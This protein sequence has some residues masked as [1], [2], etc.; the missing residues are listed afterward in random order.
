METFFTL[1][2]PVKLSLTSSEH[3]R[4]GYEQ[5]QKYSLQAGRG[6]RD[7]N[8]GYL[9]G[10]NFIDD[11]TGERVSGLRKHLIGFHETYREYFRTMGEQRQKLSRLIAEGL[12]LEISYFNAHFHRQEDHCLLNHYKAPERDN[13][14]EKIGNDDNTIGAG[15]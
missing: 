10:P 4:G 2:E 13:G 7:L 5:F 6:K 15:L 9:T 14:A 8:E 1:S 3:S 12:G 11:G